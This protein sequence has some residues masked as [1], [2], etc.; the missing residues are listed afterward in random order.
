MNK[1]TRSASDGPWVDQKDI[2]AFRVFCEKNG[3]AT[4]ENTGLLQDG[5]QVKHQGHWMALSW[6]RAFKRYTADR[7]LSLLVQS[8]ATQKKGGQHEDA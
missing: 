7:R 6:N 5:F 2:A 8:F 1:S 3:R 4:R